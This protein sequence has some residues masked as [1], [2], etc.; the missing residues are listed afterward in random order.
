LAA[1][2]TAAI[3]VTAR[4]AACPPTR[5][6][7]AARPATRAAGT[8]KA[9]TDPI[10]THADDRC[11]RAIDNESA[12]MQQAMIV[13]APAPGYLLLTVTKNATPATTNP[14]TGQSHMSSGLRYG[15][16]EAVRGPVVSESASTAT[17]SRGVAQPTI[18]RPR[19]C[20]RS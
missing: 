12:T 14:K 1:A 6:R 7:R 2:D 10:A 20:M 5:P 4:T 17:E 11:A 9:S 8:T 18:R 16:A 19:S 3:T 13:K 15:T